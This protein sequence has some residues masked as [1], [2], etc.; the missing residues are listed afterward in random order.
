V[1]APALRFAN[2]PGELR[3]LGQWSVISVAG[4]LLSVEFVADKIPA[5]DSAWDAVRTF[6]RV[7]SEAV[8]AVAAFGQFDNRVW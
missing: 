7:P 6:I 4:L 3:I 2:L 5:V 1:V 8:L